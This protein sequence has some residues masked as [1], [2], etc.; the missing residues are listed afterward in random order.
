MTHIDWNNYPKPSNEVDVKAEPEDYITEIGGILYLLQRTNQC[1]NVVCFR[2]RESDMTVLESFLEFRQHLM[3]LGIQYI[4]V[5]GNTRRYRFL[6]KLG[7]CSVLQDTDIK[8][9]NVFYIKLF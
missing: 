7:L 9:R 5:E 4:R 6:A 3:G 8:N 2:I 1:N